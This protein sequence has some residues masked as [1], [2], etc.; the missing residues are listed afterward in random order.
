MSK[1][2]DVVPIDEELQRRF[3]NEL[4]ILPLTAQLLINRGLKDLDHA[5]AFLR[6][7]INKLHDPMLLKD[8]DKAVQRLTKALE[9]G[10]RVAVCGDYDV[11][12][13]TATAL[14]KLFLTELGFSVLTHIPERIS[15]GYGLNNKSLKELA[16]QGVKVVI[17]TDCGVSNY[18][19][20]L[21]A[22]GIGMD[23]IITDHHEV[24]E[25]IPP[26]LA[27]INP[28]QDGCAFPFKGLAGVGVAFNLA[29]GLRLHLKK[30]GKLSEATQPNLKKY[31]DLVAIG[32][33]ADMVPLIDENRILV[34]C[35]I[36]QL[37]HTER[38]GLNALMNVS[39]IRDGQVSSEKISY[40]I[41]PRI[42]AAGRVSRA[43]IALE[44]LTTPDKARA[45][46]LATKLDNINS[47]RRSLEADIT[48]EA[49][50]MVDPEDTDKG[51]VL[52]SKN[53]H[54]GVIGIVA[55][56]ISGRFTKPTVMIA[57]DGDL[58]RG[59]ARG[60]I[61]NFDLLA[62]LKKCDKYLEKYGGHKAAA[63]LSIHKD[64]IEPFKKAFIEILNETIDADDLNPKIQIDAVISLDEVN[65]RLVSEIE[66]LSPFGIS[67]REPVLGA[68]DANI[69]ETRVVGIKHLQLR[70]RHKGKPIKA[71]A[72]GRGKDHPMK[73]HGFDVAFSPYI[74]TWHGKKNLSLKIKDLK[75]SLNQD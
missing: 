21:Y 58:G 6:P 2:W 55:S 31:L 23:V 41:A 66:R 51:I 32:T 1:Q 38:P 53:W 20:T 13:T 5:Q 34:K 11:D 28:K 42:N 40:Q 30:E 10:E 60:G 69:T 46:E 27:I 61:A 57:L 36:E 71:I 50:D 18:E 24:P 48:V 37:K 54:P 65:M 75:S 52:S 70:L 39:L 59:S 62:A 47:E 44:L 8:M 64:N 14:L 45:E 63:G 26:A 3:V 7:D 73:G 16:D 15:E 68:L 25:K 49:L 35:G 56:K 12:G 19:E 22:N 17:T 4:N 33:V 72:F 43:D 9:D 67:N 74:D 29:M